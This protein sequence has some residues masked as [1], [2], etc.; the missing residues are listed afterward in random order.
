MEHGDLDPLPRPERLGRIWREHHH[1]VD[2]AVDQ[3]LSGLDQIGGEEGGNDVVLEGF[4]VVFDLLPQ[5]LLVGHDERRSEADGLVLVPGAEEQ[6]DRERSEHQDGEQSWLAEECQQ[7]TSGEADE[8]DEPPHD[9]PASEV[10]RWIRS[11]NIAS[12]SMIFSSMAAT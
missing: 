8:G 10:A 3:L 11:T 12:K 5:I 9:V 6:E 2:V 4:L 1:E 7:L